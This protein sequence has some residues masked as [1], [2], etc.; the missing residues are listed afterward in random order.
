MKGHQRTSYSDTSVGQTIEPLK[1][2][3]AFWV[4]L[5]DICRDMVGTWAMQGFLRLCFEDKVYTMKLHGPMGRA[6]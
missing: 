4:G 2:I 6:K 3:R 5:P 1:R